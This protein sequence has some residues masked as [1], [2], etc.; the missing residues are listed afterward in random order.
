VDSFTV[1]ANCRDFV[2]TFLILFLKYKYINNNYK[3]LRGNF[4]LKVSSLMK[5]LIVGLIVFVICFNDFFVLSN[6]IFS[7]AAESFSE[8]ISYDFQFVKNDNSEMSIEVSIDVP[9]DRYFK[10]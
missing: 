10:N 9:S 6:A 8:D 7:Y 4:M 3:Y 2:L 1:I 5:K